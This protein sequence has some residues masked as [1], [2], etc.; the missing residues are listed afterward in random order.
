MRIDSVR[1]DASGN[2]T[3]VA[4]GGISFFIPINRI[5]EIQEG[6]PTPGIVLEDE[7]PTNVAITRIAEEEEA[8]SKGI[9]LCSRAEQ[10]TIGLGAKLASRGFSRSAIQ[11]AMKELERQGIV[12]DIRFATIWARTRAEH[13]LHGPSLLYNELK[14]RGFSENTIKSALL[15]IDFNSLLEKAIEKEL[16]GMASQTTSANSLASLTQRLKLKGFRSESIRQ[17]IEKL[18]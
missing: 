13:R 5:S 4:S 3:I 1:F 17:S 7:D 12:N 6:L 9:R 15:L 18:T 16:S 11:Y 14:A 8:L 10:S 2:A